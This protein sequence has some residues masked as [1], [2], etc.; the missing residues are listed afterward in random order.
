MSTFLQMINNRI[1][2][3]LLLGLILTIGL[4]HAYHYAFVND[5][6]FISFRYAENLVAG[7][8]LAYNAGERVEGYTNFLWTL[9]IALGLKLQIDPVLFSAILGITFHLGTLI[10]FIFI[11]NKTQRQ[12]TSSIFVIPLTSL[13]LSLNRDFN[14]YATSGLE[15]S[16]YTFF[17]V[18]GF[19]FLS[20]DKIRWNI[21][22]AGIFALLAML[23]RPDGIIF[24]ASV[25]I[26][27]IIITENKW[28]NC[29]IFL[30]PS[31][32]IFLP[33]WFWR[34][35]Y[36]G[37]FFPNSFY[38]KSIGLTYYSQGLEYVWLYFQT[39]YGLII[40]FVAGIVALWRFKTFNRITQELRYSS[41]HTILLT[42]IFSSLYI[43]F[44][45]R[46]GGDF[47]HARFLIPVTPFLYYLIERFILSL[48]K[49]YLRIILA[50]II[51]LT[52]IFRYDLYTKEIS[53]GY[54]VDE[55]QYYTHDH[56]ERTKLLGFTIKK[57]FE[58]LPVRFAFSGA[59]A[60]VIY[61][62]KTPYALE[63]LTGLTDTGLAHQNISKRGRPGHEK[64]ASIEFLQEKKIDFFIG[65]VS[66]LSNGELPI[67][68]VKIDTFILQ[69][70][71]YNK[72]IMDS[73]QKFPQIQFTQIDQYIDSYLANMKNISKETALSDYKFFHDYYFLVNKDSVR[74]REFLRQ[75]ENIRY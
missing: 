25:L 75:L 20:L 36:F 53:V 49:S 47:M 15:T 33:Y 43:L 11:S 13:L 19:L 45:I 2:I 68:A 65:P 59:H 18:A 54:V 70:V 71:R 12:L 7:N 41:N 52:T 69:I 34:W 61:Y 51:T 26:Y 27:F 60:R 46:I 5:D 63:A 17:I 58:R 3:I 37:F 24:L 56:L 42:G 62:S 10:L 55:V 14:V 16:M 8:G 35:N 28:K 48:S 64:S 74:E 40:L 50:F 72:S 57:Y 23:T 39:Y 66:T 30:I 1:W 22:I 31:I 9:L 4:I 73:L 44:V 29:L 38:A 67:N 21:L 6:A 32:F